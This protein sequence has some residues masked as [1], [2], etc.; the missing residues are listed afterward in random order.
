MSTWDGNTVAGLLQHVFGRD[1]TT[2]R[3]TCAGCGREGLL[4]EAQVFLGAGT[5]LRCPSCDAVL[6]VLVPRGDMYGVDLRGMSVLEG[7]A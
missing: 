1:M 6:V 2:A 5:V 4:G 3:G 7:A